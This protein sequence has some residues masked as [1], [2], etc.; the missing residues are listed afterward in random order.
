MLVFH[1]SWFPETPGSGKRCSRSVGHSGGGFRRAGA[2]EG[3]CSLQES[4]G[5]CCE[6]RGPSPAG[7]H[8]ETKTVPRQHRRVAG[9]HVVVTGTKGARNPR[10]A[11]VLDLEMGRSQGG[12]REP[13]GPTPILPPSHSHV[14]APPPLTQLSSAHLLRQP[15]MTLRLALLCSVPLTVPQQRAERHGTAMC[16]TR[17]LGH[18]RHGQGNCLS[19]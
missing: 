15:E 19:P 10:R 13:A 18:Y 11:R 14:P 5:Q 12:Q 17:A 6:S 7:G 1:S 9:A 2:V 4:A 16:M 8:R 3:R